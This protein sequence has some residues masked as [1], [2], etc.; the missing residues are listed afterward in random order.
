[1][2]SARK[3]FRMADGDFEIPEI[4]QD[5][6]E[7]QRYFAV[8]RKNQSSFVFVPLADMLRRSGHSDIALQVC[9]KGLEYHPDS[10]SGRMI[11]ASVY[12]ELGQKYEADRT[13]REILARMPGHP[14]AAKFLLGESAHDPG[15]TVS[16]REF[17]SLAPKTITMAEILAGQ[18]AY[19]E[20]ASIIKALLL[21][22]PQNERLQQYLREW[23]TQER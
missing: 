13:A 17:T 19:R 12:F 16:E 4:L 15:T 5:H 10:V 7:F 11:L 22:D 20:A 21:R 8:W 6:P 23:E 1:M 3:C 14:E 18:G 9:E 2:V